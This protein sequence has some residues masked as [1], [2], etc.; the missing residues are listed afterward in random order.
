MKP[1]R[2]VHI[3]FNFEDTD[4]PIEELEKTLG[5]TKDWLRYGYQ[6]WIIYTGLELDELR[7]RIR[8]TAGLDNTVSFFL[9]EFKYYSGYMPDWVWKWLQK[10][11]TLPT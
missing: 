11:R 9:T 10:D 3:G 7:D 5:K 1:P 6:G 2:L 4:P 8:N